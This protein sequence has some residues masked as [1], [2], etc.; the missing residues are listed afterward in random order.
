[1]EIP[2]LRFQI[3]FFY[4]L[5]IKDWSVSA[6]NSHLVGGMKYHDGKLIVPITGRYNIYLHTYF[7]STYGRIYVDV[8]GKSVTMTQTPGTNG[9]VTKHAAG[10]FNL[11]AGDIIT[12]SAAVD[13]KPFM[14]SIHTYFGA[15]LIQE[16]D[17]WQLHHNLNN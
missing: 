12:V 4:P 16:F 10:V 1:M 8:N 9:E 13:C 14:G 3:T 2:R 11:K 15:Y 5:V 17:E 6:P 7:H